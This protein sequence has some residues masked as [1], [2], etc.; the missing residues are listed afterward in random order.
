MRRYETVFLL[1]PEMS[2]D[3]VSQALERYQSLVAGNAGETLRLDD[4]GQRPLAYPVKKHSR[5]HYALLDY[6]GE[7][8]T[9]QELERNLR[10][11]ERC[12]KFLTVKVAESADP[13]A[14]REQL[15]K[16]A[17]VQA[18]E[19]EAREVAEA[20]AREAAEAQAAQRAVEA[21]AA[22]Q[23]AEAQAAQQAAASS[24][25]PPATEPDKQGEES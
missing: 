1:N 10:I 16:E 22:Q 3:Q 19:A 6:C 17:E 4:W 24:A 18:A 7:P 13:A 14:I 21:Q 20:A 12:L 25:E 8:K 9:V 5:G 23:A 15:R 2:G 11:D